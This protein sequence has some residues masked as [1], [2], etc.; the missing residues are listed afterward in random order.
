MRRLLPAMLVIAAVAL[1]ATPAQAGTAVGG[2]SAGINI[3]QAPQGSGV[4]CLIF[5]GDTVQWSSIGSVHTNAT[6]NGFVHYSGDMTV[7]AQILDHD[8][9]RIVYQGTSPAS[10]DATLFVDP[11]TG[12]HIDT[13]V[14]IR[15]LSVDSPS[16]AITVRIDFDNFVTRIDGPST[17]N[18]Y[19]YGLMQTDSFD[20]VTCP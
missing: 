4:T 6:G 9:S 7:T 10:F 14:T 3:F 2:S 8:G 18:K 19:A 12:A 16:V 13:P 17:Q 15:L 11:I 5:Y 20:D 1:A